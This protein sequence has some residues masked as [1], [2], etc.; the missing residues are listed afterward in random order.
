[1]S[2]NYLSVINILMQLRKVY[3]IL[4]FSF[5]GWG[6]GRGI[7]GWVGLEGRALMDGW[8]GLEVGH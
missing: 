6:W 3:S 5:S 2:G 1:M 8:V 4:R 7:D